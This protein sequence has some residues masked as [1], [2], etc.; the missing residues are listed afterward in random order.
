LAASAFWLI[1]RAR[2]CT[3]FFAGRARGCIERAAVA[4]SAPLKV[5]AME[6]ITIS[7]AAARRDMRLSSVFL[8]G[9]G[10][11]DRRLVNGCSKRWVG[12]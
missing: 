7:S 6:A 8:G 12:D 9:P 5:A 1:L 3:A 10:K 11:G 2:W 4:E